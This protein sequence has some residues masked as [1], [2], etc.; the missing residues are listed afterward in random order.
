[1]RKVCSASLPSTL[2]RTGNVIVVLQVSKQYIR[3]GLT[4]SLGDNV[5]IDAT[6]E[7]GGSTETVRV[8]GETPQLQTETSSTGAVLEG[9]YLQGLPLYQRNVK[10][11]FYLTP[12]V[13]VQGFGYSG[14]LQGFHIDGLQDTKIGY[15]QDGSY[16]VANNNGTVYT[17]DQSKARLKR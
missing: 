6:L 5:S 7:P 8:T 4:L 2:V 14:N 1:M 12:G 15:F 9:A 17:T 16:A 10:A 3:E 11:A 13:E